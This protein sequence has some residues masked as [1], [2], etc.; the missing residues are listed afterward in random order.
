MLV[1]DF[2]KITLFGQII[3]INYGFDNKKHWTQKGVK[4]DKME[5]FN[6]YKIIEVRSINKNEISISIIL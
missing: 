5:S 1:K 6:N 4:D 2:M 3:Q